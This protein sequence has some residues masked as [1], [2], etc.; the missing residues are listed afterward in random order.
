MSQPTNFVASRA[1]MTAEE[2]KA[3]ALA[4][5]KSRAIKGTATGAGIA[6]GAAGAELALQ[7]AAVAAE[8]TVA[9][10][11]TIAIVP[12]VLTVAV[13]GGACYGTYRLVKWICD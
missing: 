11:E 7:G 4:Q 3:A 5:L 12:T 10:V 8:A 6:A 13:I 2:A 1:P 9:A